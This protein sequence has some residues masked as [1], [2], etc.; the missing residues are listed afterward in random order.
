MSAF[1]SELKFHHFQFLHPIK[2]SLKS[3]QT[4]RHKPDQKRSRAQ[5]PNLCHP[6]P[7]TGRDEKEDSLPAAPT[8]PGEADVRGGCGH[9]HIQGQDEGAPLL[10][11]LVPS[12][13]PQRGSQDHSPGPTSGS[14]LLPVEQRREPTR[15]TLR[16]GA[17]TVQTHKLGN[18]GEQPG[19]RK[20]RDYCQAGLQIFAL[21]SSKGHE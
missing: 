1:Q 18:P 5:N 3:T 16:P 21:S 19:T 17:L 10:Q 9:A 15:V 8:P 11:C 20:G 13:Q 6:A 2:L 14:K 12:V 4:L 7:A